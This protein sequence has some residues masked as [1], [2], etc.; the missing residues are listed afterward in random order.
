MH[1]GG[2][3]F[4]RIL[5]GSDEGQLLVFHLDGAHGVPGLEL[6]FGRHHGDFLALMAAVRVKQAAEGPGVWT[7][8]GIPGDLR[9][10]IGVAED[11]ADAGH[12]A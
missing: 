4:R 9:F 2:A 1:S 6:R 5:H 8:G 7:F 11:G 10:L 3:G 12:F